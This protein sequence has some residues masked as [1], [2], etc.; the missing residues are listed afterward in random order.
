MIAHG[1]CADVRISHWSGPAQ[2][3]K[4]DLALR[5]PSACREPCDGRGMSSVKRQHWQRR[6][7]HIHRT[8]AAISGHGMMHL[9]NGQLPVHNSLAR[10]NESAKN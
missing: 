5:R 2:H 7:G 6:H 8:R 3:S 10:R 9:D 1:Q 4:P